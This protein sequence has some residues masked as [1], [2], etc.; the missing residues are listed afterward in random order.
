MRMQEVYMP[1]AQFTKMDL[2][3]IPVWISNHM[4]NKV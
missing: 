4:P 1:E 2:T 3:F